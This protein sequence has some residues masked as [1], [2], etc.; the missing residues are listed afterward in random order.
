MFSDARLTNFIANTLALLAVLAMLAGVVVWV[1]QRPYFS[2]AQIKIEPMQA[3]TLNYVSAASVQATIAGQIKGNFFSLDLDD[4]RALIET[5]PWIRHASIRRVWPDALAIQIEE[6]QPLALWNEDQMINTWGEAF[7]ANQGELDDDADL[8]QL[9][10]PDSSERLV[11]QRYAEI[12]R[13]FAPLNLRV[14]E[15][16][17]SPRYA[18][19]VRLSDGVYLSLG[20]D[21]AADVADPHG[22]AGAL[23]FAARIERF[24]QAWPTLAQRLDGRV[25]SNADL[26]YSNGF[27]ITLAPV[28]NTSTK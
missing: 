7:A 2:I 6:Q 1:A 4:T 25:I 10:G 11:V 14:Q 28:S 15:V 27:A 26:R 3:D 16:T 20:R 13:W 23:P 22:R 21:P 5:V 17:L 24:V 9:S 18:W 19:E 8:P 12:A